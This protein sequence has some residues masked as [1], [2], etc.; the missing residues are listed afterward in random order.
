MLNRGF[1]ISSFLKDNS[2][3]E[4]MGMMRSKD[5]GLF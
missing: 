5:H 2:N 4:K 1:V 3:E